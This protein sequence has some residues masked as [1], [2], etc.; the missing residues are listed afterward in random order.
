[1]TYF[2]WSE[3]HIIHMNKLK[4]PVSAIVSELSVLHFVVQYCRNKF[5]MVVI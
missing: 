1:M 3:L 4:I 2:L 5:Q